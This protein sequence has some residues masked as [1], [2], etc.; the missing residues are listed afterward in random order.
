MAATRVAVVVV[1]SD[2]VGVVF[3]LVTKSKSELCKPRAKTLNVQRRQRNFCD[4]PRYV[5]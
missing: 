2:V 3:G 4:S 1:V 5:E